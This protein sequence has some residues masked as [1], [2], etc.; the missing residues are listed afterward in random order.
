[1]LANAGAED[2]DEDHDHVVD[3]DDDRRCCTEPDDGRA[4]IRVILSP[5]QP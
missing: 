4:Q 3:C 1:M 2:D 5:M